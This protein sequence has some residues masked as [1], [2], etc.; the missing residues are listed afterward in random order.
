MHTIALKRIKLIVS[1]MVS[2]GITREFR[3]LKLFRRI[4][5]MYFKS[6]KVIFMHCLI[7]PDPNTSAIIT[8]VRYKIDKNKIHE[9]DF[10]FPFENV[11]HTL[12]DKYIDKVYDYAYLNCIGLLPYPPNAMF[13]VT[14]KKKDINH[15]EI[16][17]LNKKKYTPQEDCGNQK[18]ND[19]DNLTQHTT[20]ENDLNKIKYTSENPYQKEI[21]LYNWHVEQ[22]RLYWEG[23]LS[24][25][26]I[27][28]LESIG[29]DWNHYKQKE[30]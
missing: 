25:E 22:T 30:K 20:P 12:D 29:F 1:E 13:M 10:C 15:E 9:T 18:D 27:D 4:T 14:N 19:M 6:R 16:E 26:K 5:E 11:G 21:D 8:T 2:A 17:F 28:K 3:D 23:K 24:K 7:N